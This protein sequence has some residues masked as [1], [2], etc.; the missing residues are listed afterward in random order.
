MKKQYIL[1]FILC[2]A[3]AQ[4]AMAQGGSLNI[5]PGAGTYYSIGT[6]EGTKGTRYLFDT[7]VK[8]SVTD[9]KGGVIKNDSYSF[10]YDKVDGGLLLTQ[11]K[12]TAIM[13]GKDQVKG[14]TVYDN[15]GQAL[16]FE[17]VPAIDATHYV[18]VLSAGS[19]YKVYKFT[20]TK[21]E[22]ANFKSDGMTSSG[23]KYDEYVDAPGYYVFNV[24]T[25]SLQMVALKSKAIK[26][27]FSADADKVKAF[28]DAHKDDDINEDFLKGLGEA[29]N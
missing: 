10:N 3:A 28:F 14:F 2:L 4:L 20:K 24:K 23:N 5:A 17:Y 27:V 25:A 7:W 11:D 1:S 19:N 12:Q 8:G 22:K 26:Q 21:F 16:T 9:G 6:K 15:T 29:L 13:L 18:Q